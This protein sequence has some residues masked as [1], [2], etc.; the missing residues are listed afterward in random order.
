MD[1]HAAEDTTRFRMGAVLTVQYCV[2]STYV[3]TGMVF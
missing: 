3:S 1:L 2:A